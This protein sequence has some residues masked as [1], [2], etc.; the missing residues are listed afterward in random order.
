MVIEYRLIPV[1]ARS[2]AWVCGRSV[3]GNAGS[4][5][6]G[7]MDVVSC[8]CCVLSGSGLCVGLITRPEESYRVSEASV[9]SRFWPA[10]D[11]CA[12]GAGETKHRHRLLMAIFA[13]FC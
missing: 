10:G 4:N 13:H 8:E 7:A 5:H 3:A 12:K 9:M 6:V 1:S 11:Y 2:K